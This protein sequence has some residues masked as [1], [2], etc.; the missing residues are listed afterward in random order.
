MSLKSILVS[1]LAAFIPVWI[2]EVVC[3][4]IEETTKMWIKTIISGL[5]SFIV[6]FVVTWILEIV[7][8]GLNKYHGQWVEELTCQD[9]QEIKKC[10]AIGIIRYDKKTKEH[11][12]YG[13]TFSLEGEELYT[14]SI[15]YLRPDKDNAMEYVCCVENP[16]ERSMGKITFLN[17]NE[18]RGDIWVM[19]GVQ[20]KF[21]AYRITKELLKSIGFGQKT[22]CLFLR[23]KRICQKNYPEFIINYLTN[24]K[25]CDGIEVYK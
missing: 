1:V 3:R 17:R 15:D 6:L 4:V 22:K 16:D 21:N 13:S 9:N 18:C 12:F 14:W 10:L 7:L 23:G 8:N 11:I 2:Y 24:N 20:Y 5:L 19:N 25:F